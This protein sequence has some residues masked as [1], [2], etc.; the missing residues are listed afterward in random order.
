[1]P[2]NRRVHQKG[3]LDA[4]LENGARGVLE[5]MG[6]LNISHQ[7]REDFVRRLAEDDEAE[8]SKKIARERTRITTEVVL[9]GRL[10]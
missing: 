8:Q 10:K 5:G 3:R 6:K 7:E 9:P 4:D 2:K 1:M